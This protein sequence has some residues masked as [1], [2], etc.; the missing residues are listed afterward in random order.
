V[1]ERIVHTRQW[2][3]LDLRQDLMAGGKFEHLGDEGGP[4]V[5]DP[6]TLFSFITRST[7]LIPIGSI[8][9][10]SMCSRPCGCSVL[11]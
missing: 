6:E 4:A 10:P 1:I 9:I 11:V 8:T 7:A 2:K 3:I 5:G